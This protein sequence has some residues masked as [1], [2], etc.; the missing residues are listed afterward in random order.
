[1]HVHRYV[2]V[3]RVSHGS[4]AECGYALPNKAGVLVLVLLCNGRGEGTEGVIIQPTTYR[5]VP[6]LGQVQGLTPRRS[7]PGRW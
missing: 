3:T 5:V 2:T 1:M 7:V 6:M 4:V